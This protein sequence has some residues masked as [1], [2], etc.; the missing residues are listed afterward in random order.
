M[1]NIH[2]SISSD[3]HTTL[4]RMK[5][6]IQQQLNINISISS[7]YNGC[8]QMRFKYKPPQHEQQ[9]TEQQKL[10]IFL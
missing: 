7:V 10:N 1:A 6:N 3:A 9:L 4:E 2:G 5:T 8:M